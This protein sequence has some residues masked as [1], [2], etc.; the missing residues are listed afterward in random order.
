MLLSFG[1]LSTQVDKY[2]KRVRACYSGL[3]GT[4]ERCASTV[5]R[6]SPW[7]SAFVAYLQF[8]LPLKQ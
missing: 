1:M 2:G 4:G 6:C 7:F 8:C 3:A 5:R